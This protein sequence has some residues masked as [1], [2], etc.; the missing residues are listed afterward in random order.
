MEK[1]LA[2]IAGN[3][4]KIAAKEEETNLEFEDKVIDAV[5]LDV[6]MGVL[7]GAIHLA[8]LK[9]KLGDAAI[10]NKEYR[11]VLIKVADQWA[12]LHMKVRDFNDVA[13]YIPDD[14]KSA[15]VSQGFAKKGAH[16]LSKLTKK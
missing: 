7:G 14:H 12:G 16:N 8:D 4:T 1:K 5:G 6:L 9:Q 13:Q 2:N 11:D 10:D 3:F 15:E